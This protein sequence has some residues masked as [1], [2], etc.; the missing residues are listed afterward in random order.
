MKLSLSFNREQGLMALKWILKGVAIYIILSMWIWDSHWVQAEIAEPYT[1]VLAWELEKILRLLGYEVVRNQ[2]FLTVTGLPFVIKI[3]PRCLGFLGGGFFIF[4]ACV[5]TLPSS[6]LRSKVFWLSIGSL[7]LTVTNIL[8]ITI[9]IV[10]SFEDPSSFDLVHKGSIDV[11]TLV[12]GVLALLAFRSLGL[13][14]KGI[15]VFRRSAARGVDGAEG[16]AQGG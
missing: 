4:L 16:G 14:P 7:A 12:G 6:S 13:K 5:L 1:R 11:N 15:N 10:L 8:R 3:I 2:S 9:V